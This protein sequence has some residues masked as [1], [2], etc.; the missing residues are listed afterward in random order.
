VNTKDLRDLVSFSEDGPHHASL[1]ESGFLWSEVVCLQG[2]QGLGPISDPDSDA[3]CA[4][5]AGRIAVQVDRDRKRLSQWGSV[6]VPAGSEL[7]IRNASAEPAVILLVAAPPPT[8]R[9]VYE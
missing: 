3:I 9:A 7:T 6:L 5:V 1:F 4:V 2:A 8:P